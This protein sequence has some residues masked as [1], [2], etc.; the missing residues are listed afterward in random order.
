MKQVKH[1]SGSSV[2]YAASL[3]LWI[4]CAS[5]VT[6]GQN[7]VNTCAS[8]VVRYER[9]EVIPGI[10]EKLRSCARTYPNAVGPHLSRGRLLEESGDLSAAVAEFEYAERLAPRNVIAAARLGIA[11]F[12]LPNYSRALAAFQKAVVLAPEDQSLQFEL[13]R[14]QLALKL[15]HDSTVTARRIVQLGATSTVLNRLAAMQTHA[16]DY[17][18]AA[19]NLERLVSLSPSDPAAQYN[20]GLAYLKGGDARRAIEV[21]I[22]LRKDSGDAEIENLLGEAYEGTGQYYEALRSFQRAAEMVPGSE[23]Y[24]F[25]YILE[26]LRHNTYDAA[27]LIAEPSVKDFHSS[28]RIQTALG[29]ALMG[30]KDYPKACSQLVET[31][32]AFPESEFALRMLVEAAEAGQTNTTQAESLVR[33]YLREHEDRSIPWYLLGRLEMQKY[34]SADAEP[35]LRRSAELNPKHAETQLEWGKALSDLGRKAE[36]ENRYRRAVQLDPHF[37]EAW[38]RLSNTLRE[39]GKSDEARVAANRSIDLRAQDDNKELRKFIYEL[40]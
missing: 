17:H 31:A 40:R 27:V 22:P 8:L 33:S 29:L 6:L 32:Q 2:A 18:G 11:L 10:G 19:V 20:L 4:L 37:T 15:F 7:V 3:L 30:K 24:R 35:L 39:L 12:K 36:A 34:N 14:T 28:L 13:F 1:M 21:L 26:L 25:D 5:D 23:D 38:F 9:G 16:G